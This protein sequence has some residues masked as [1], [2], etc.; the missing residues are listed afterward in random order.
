MTYKS[1]MLILQ[2]RGAS[3]DT[4]D[5]ILSSAREDGRWS[6]ATCHCMVTYDA[7]RDDYYVIGE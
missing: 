7:D 1:V 3:E 4:A 6:T 5:F 2:A